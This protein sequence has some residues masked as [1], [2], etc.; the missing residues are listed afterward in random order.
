MRCFSS[1]R[2]YRR[3]RRLLRVLAHP[4][5][6]SSGRSARVMHP[7]RGYGSRRDLF[8]MGRVFRQPGLGLNLEEGL[9][10][11]VANIVRRTVRWGVR[12]AR[13]RVEVAG[14]ETVVTS[15]R[16]GYFRVWLPVR[17]AL[18][19][20]AQWLTARLSLLPAG[21][22]EPGRLPGEAPQTPDIEARIY[23]PPE[24]VD[25]GVISDI[26]DTVIYTG[27][28]SKLAMMYRLF[29][30]KARHRTAFPGVSSFYRALFHG[31]DGRAGRPMLY[32]SRGPWS[33]YEMLTEFFRLNKIPHGP[34][35][36][37]R[38]WG[39]TLQRPLP[40]H[41]RN[42]KRRLISEMLAMYPELPFIL[43]G[44][45]GQ[46]DPEVYAEIVARYPQRIRAI[47]IRHVHQ[48]ARR[49]RALQALARQ[50]A[51]QGCEMIL[52]DDSLEMADHALRHGWISEA[53]R[54][55]VRHDCRLRA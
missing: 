28:A 41:A 9:M 51:G 33:I 1:A 53:G 19:P 46:R 25:C 43:I 4:A 22:G 44:D 15:D 3:L 48:S 16:D 7:Y 45:S 20:N 21:E 36:F 2:V 39:V 50:V 13:V 42:Y 27:V 10:D 5:R 24:K 11:D 32:V 40:L 6:S 34:V 49:D 35:L 23:I 29:I 52:A 38:E 54:N 55:E 31:A 18:P 14:S 17:E 47:Y 8:L 37:L 12:D 30:Q 26:D